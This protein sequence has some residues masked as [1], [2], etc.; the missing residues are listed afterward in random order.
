VLEL[1]AIN[2]GDIYI[3]NTNRNWFIKNKKYTVTDI[4][5]NEIILDKYFVIS[6]E[7]LF[8]YFENSILN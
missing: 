3:S 6:K 7:Y 1:E 8:K 2:I 5:E 4:K